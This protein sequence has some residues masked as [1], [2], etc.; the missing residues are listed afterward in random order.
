MLYSVT[1]DYMLDNLLQRASEKAKLR[2]DM[3]THAETMAVSL[4][5]AG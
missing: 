2:L 3:I 1:R 4:H 5:S